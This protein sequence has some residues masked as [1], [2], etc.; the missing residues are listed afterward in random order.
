MTISRVNLRREIG[1]RTGQPFFRRF[2]KTSGAASTTG[3]TTTLIDTVLLKEE[4]NFWRGNFI[5]FPATDELREI[6]AFTQSSSTVTWL[7]AIGTGTTTAQVYEIWS[8]FTPAEVHSALDHALLEA[9]PFFFEYG[10]D[11]SLVVTQDTGLFYTLPTTNTI[12][13]LAQVYVMIYNG[14]QGSVTTEGTTT[15]II[16][17]NANFV[18][19]DVGKW[20]SVY[21]DGGSANG[22]IR[23]ITVRDSATQ[24]TVG[25]AF[26][27]AAPV[28]AKYRK[29]DKG[30]STPTQVLLDNW[31]VNKNT[32]PTQ[33]W[34]G[35][36]LSGYEGYPLYL[37]Y[38]YEFPVLA[39]ET[40]TTN[41]PT[42]YL[43]SSIL[44]YLYQLKL[45]T[46]PA[47]EVQNWDALHKAM[48]NAAQLFVS[49]HK[50]THLPASIIRHNLG[51]GNLPA[52]YPFRG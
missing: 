23:Q 4:N 16:D 32:F 12:R 31:I 47:T 3:T 27:G 50:Y 11:E 8:T 34:L 44:A 20:I 29:L 25:T 19:A 51:H 22:Q 30:D 1:K 10:T 36:H 17:A 13:R 52:D 28:G 7:A 35:A 40:A 33:L 43:V 37:L 41:A 38:E 48:A 39:T 5:Y 42:E 18:A 6:S 26:S 15:Q 21:K 46:S 9:W 24:V 49:A 2:G 45:A 14:T